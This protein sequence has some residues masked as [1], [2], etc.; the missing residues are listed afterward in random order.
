MF[1]PDPRRRGEIQ[2]LLARALPYGVRLGVLAVLLGAGLLLQLLVNLWAGAFFLLLASLLATVRGFSNIPEVPRGRREWRGAER[3]QLEQVLRIAKKAKQWDQSIF[4]VT[5]FLGVFALVLLVLVIASVA[6]LLLQAKEEWLARAWILD[7]AVLLL[8]HWLTGIRRV[9]TNDP[10]TIRVRQLL[11]VYDAWEKDRGAGER[12]LP[13]LEVASG[14]GGELPLDAKLVLR[15]DSLGDDF[16]GLQVQ[17]VLNRVQ[18]ADF[19]YLYCV[20]VAR[21]PLGML[22]QLEQLDPCPAHNLLLEAK[23]E[24]DVEIVV[25]RRQT[26]KTSGYHT[27]PA[28]SRRI[29]SLALGLA[30][31]LRAPVA[32]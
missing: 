27:K 17:V 16:L 2:F 19:P 18:G 30:R 11:L 3:E 15:M 6:F 29:F 9:L 22:D 28:M 31:K 26:T 12:M 32:G 24:G 25:V 21:P 7:S 13:Q 4:D 14:Q 1:L 5:C 20:L 8:P 23:Q 10:L